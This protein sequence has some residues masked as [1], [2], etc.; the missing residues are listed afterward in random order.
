MK[1]Y[2]R[3]SL[4]LFFIGYLALLFYLLYFSQYRSYILSLQDRQLNIVPL[5][6]I[7]AYFTTFGPLHPKMVMDNFFGNVL[8]FAPFGLLVPLIWKRMRGLRKVL[9]LSGAFSLVIEILQYVSRVG[10]GDVDDVF[11][12]TLGGILGYGCFKI[13]IGMVSNKKRMFILGEE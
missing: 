5:R 11:L 6:T 13:A 3:M 2:L 4:Y 10:A 7:I 8:A 1:P 9:F 12:N